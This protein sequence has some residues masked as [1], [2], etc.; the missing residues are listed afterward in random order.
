MTKRAQKVKFAKQVLPSRKVTG[1]P[2]K[3]DAAATV[4]CCRTEIKNGPARGVEKTRFWDFKAEIHN[5]RI[6]EYWHY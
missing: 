4:S 3:T 1:T 6:S 5:T 2:G